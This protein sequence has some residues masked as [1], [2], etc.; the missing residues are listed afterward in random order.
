MRIFVDGEEVSRLPR[1]AAILELDRRVC[2]CIRRFR[3]DARMKW[4]YT[5]VYHELI[6]RL[7]QSPKE[8]RR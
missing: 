6:K 7:G 3:H 2:W 5:R 4:F 1:Y 8:K